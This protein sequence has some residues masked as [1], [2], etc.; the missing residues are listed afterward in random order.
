MLRFELGRTYTRDEISS[1][2]GGS[3]EPYLPT[4]NGRVTYGAFKRDTNPEA[5]HVVL[6]GFGPKIEESAELLARQRDPIP[7]FT[8]PATAATLGSA[9]RLFSCAGVLTPRLHDAVP[10]QTCR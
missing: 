9:P 3:P 6:P 5:P 4:K 7:V 2:L 1:E 10:V 8:A